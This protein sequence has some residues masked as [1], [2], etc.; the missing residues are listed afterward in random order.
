MKTIL[1][2]FKIGGFNNS[3]S[4]YKRSL[5]IHHFRKGELIASLP[6][7]EAGSIVP[8][9]LADGDSVSFEKRWFAGRTRGSDIMEFIPSITD[10][11]KTFYASFY[12]ESIEEKEIK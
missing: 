12:P 6:G 7:V 11:M 5:V 4:G 8:M 1:Y 2:K 3:T 9:E 10:K